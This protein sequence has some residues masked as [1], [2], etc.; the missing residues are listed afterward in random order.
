[1]CV[2]SCPSKYWVYLE[3]EA[4][5][6]A[7]TA[8]TAD[9]EELLCKNSVTDAQGTILAGSSA[10]NIYLYFSIYLIAKGPLLGQLIIVWG[11]MLVSASLVNLDNLPIS[12]QATAY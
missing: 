9:Y 12:T 7:S 1:M 10:V 5:V 4:K 3:L 6:V 2:A 11:F 8:N